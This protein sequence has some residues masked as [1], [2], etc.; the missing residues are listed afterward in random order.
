MDLETADFI[1]VGGGS[2]GCVL[3]NRLSENPNHKVILLEAGGAGDKL[4]T[5]MPAGSY[6]MLG[7]P[8]TDWIYMTEPDPSLGGRR[9]PWS[10]G[11]VLGGGSTVN[12]MVYI[13]GSRQDYD[14]LAAQGCTGWSWDEVQ[15]YFK[16][17][18]KFSG[19]RTRSHSQ[20]GNLGVA[21]PRMEHPLAGTFV[22]ACKELGLRE[23]EDYC[24]G[25]IDGTFKNFV[26]QSNG[27]RASAACAF[28]QPALRRPNLKIITDA[29][30]DRIIIENGRAAG[31]EFLQAGTKRT[32]RCRREVIISAGSIQSPAILMRSGIGPSGALQALGIDVKYDAPEVG[33]NL[34]EHASFASSYFVNV[35]TYNTMLGPVKN[36]RHVLNYLLFRKGVMTAAPVEAMA[37]LRSTPELAE[38]D[39][40]LQFGA[41]CFDRTKGKPHERAG[42]VIYAN[43]AKPRSRGE[44]RLRSTNPVDKP[45]IDHRLLGHPADVTALVRGIKQVDRIFNAP[46]F[47][48]FLDGRHMPAN[49][50]KDDAEWEALL[51]AN[52][53]I[54]YHPV[55]TC[56][57][58]ADTA[59]VVDPQ[60]RV[61]GIA[62]LRVADASIIPLM[63]SANT[64]AP[65][66]MVGE[67]A[68]DMILADTL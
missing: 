15:P 40:K 52:S 30:A 11:R 43:V 22:A 46:A 4:L 57:M 45:V 50:P 41:V 32:I 35:P 20:M 59:S 14:S 33:Q 18:E 26:T 55:G 6:R 64:N 42:V 68:S 34:Q 49:T 65:A 1:I 25:D 29:L 24:E 51:R 61:R 5:T 48:K 60:L 67:K 17:S 62:G 31:V 58:G 39:I 8:K 47:A 23:V 56:R 53:H 16:K 44:I 36:L 54:G 7:K 27:Q 19:A 13:R 63:P 66:I 37:Y 10:A 21:P 38:P 3:A 12:G 28:L 9:V 2:A